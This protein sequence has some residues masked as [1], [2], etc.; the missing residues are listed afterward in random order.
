MRMHVFEDVAVAYVTAALSGVYPSSTSGCTWL[1]FAL[2]AVAVIHLCYVLLVRP[3]AVRLEQWL[4]VINGVLS[5][6]VAVC[7]VWTRLA[8]DNRRNGPSTLAMAYCVLAANAFYFIQLVVLTIG[9]ATQSYARRS[10]H[11]KEV[12]SPLLLVPPAA[13][14][15][16]MNVLPVA[17]VLHPEPK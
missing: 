11:T 8:N 14:V 2:L 3:F 1:C 13:D 7:A 15:I 6:G 16:R 9:A 5:T 10:H 17:P 12:A 4:A